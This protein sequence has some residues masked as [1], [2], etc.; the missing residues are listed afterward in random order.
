MI[1]AIKPSLEE[2]SPIQ[3]Q[4]DALSYIG[5]RGMASGNSR[6]EW[7]ESAWRIL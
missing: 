3:S 2:G 6:E 4:E 5:S 7:V 1:N